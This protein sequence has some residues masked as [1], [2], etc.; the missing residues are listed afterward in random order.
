MAIVNGTSAG[1][2]ID[3]ADGVTNG[4]DIITGFGGDDL[5]KG[6]GGNDDIMGGRGADTIDG[7][8]GSDTANYA[9]SFERVIVTLETG[10][11]YGGTAE[12]D[13]LIRIENVTGSSYDDDLIGNDGSNVLNGR[14]GNDA[15]DG[16][17]GG[18]RLIGG[19][20]FD[21]ASYLGSP[22][23]VA[24][25]LITDAAAGGD[26]EGDDLDSIENLFGSSY[27][28][29]L[30]GDDGINELVGFSGD[31]ILKGFGG[32]DTLRG[33]NQRDTLDGGDGNDRLHGEDGDDSLG[34]GAGR[35]NLLGGRGADTFVW[36][37]T[38]DTG[39]IAATAD[40]I[41]DFDRDEGDRIKLS[42]IDA[43]LYAAGNQAF[44]FI[45]TAA[46]SGTPGE[47]RYYHVGGDTFIEMQTGTVVDIEGLI[48]LEGIHTPEASWFVL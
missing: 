12:D 5:I 3:G 15:L 11:G 1:E 10:R 40:V 46:F 45:G 48:V 9:D 31:D 24:V 32:N 30:L 41:V 44:T 42:G 47:L 16:G 23:G 7:G 26:A 2:R 35:D 36:S 6:F 14:D 13:R 21:S 33:G 20:G 22:A 8:S 29:T 38:G 4:A 43:D 34:G 19:A 37:E 18:D 27:D 25:S 28:D 17:G 39:L